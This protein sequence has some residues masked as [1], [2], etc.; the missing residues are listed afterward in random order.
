MHTYMWAGAI[1]AYD[2]SY[3]YYRAVSCTVDMRR[4][5]RAEGDDVMRLV[6]TS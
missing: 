6:T 2:T 4:E 1:Y 5:V 3:V